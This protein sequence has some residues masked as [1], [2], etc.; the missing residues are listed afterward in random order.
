MTQESYDKTEPPTSKRLKDARLKGYVAKSQDLTAG[1]LLFLTMGAFLFFI[2]TMYQELCLWCIF[3]L[4]QLH[5][6]ITQIDIVIFGFQRGIYQFLALLLPLFLAIMAFAVFGNV[7]QFGFLATIDPLIPRWSRLNVFDP[8]NYKRFLSLQAM[9]RVLSNMFRLNTVFLISWGIAATVLFDVYTLSRGDGREIMP[10]IYRYLLISG[11]IVSIFFLLMGIFDYIY[12][13]VLYRRKL[14]MS[15]REVQQEQREAEV[16][17]AI[18]HRMRRLQAKWGS[19]NIKKSIMQAN[20][21]LINRDTHALA[22]AYQPDKMRAP[23][24]VAKGANERAE[25]MIEIAK[26]YQIFTIENAFFAQALF[27]AVDINLEIPPMYYSQIAEILVR[28]TKE[29]NDE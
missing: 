24:C 11:A 29:Q 20:V 26:E 2:P 27:N 23:V 21:L 5:V 15:K 1:V 7:L 28:A 6:D 25:L 9:A 13:K 16:D 14:S 17:P 8:E 18:K 10:F 22:I 19:R 3:L 4:H 12:Q